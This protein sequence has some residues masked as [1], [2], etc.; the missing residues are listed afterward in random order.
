[1]KKALLVILLCIA[2]P[3]NADV[4]IRN[5]IS[6]ALADTLYVNVAGDTMTGGLLG[7]AGTAASVSF[8]FV[9][10]ADTGLFLSAANAIGFATAGT[11]RWLIN[12]SGSLNPATSNSLDI[13]GSTTIRDIG[14]GR[15]AVFSGATSGTTTVAA[16]AVAG[17]TTLTLPAATDTLVGKATTDTLSNKTFQ[18]PGTET[19]RAAGVIDVSSATVG[20]DAN[21]TEKTLYT[22]TLPAGTLD[23][24][25]KA[26]RVL[27]S[28]EF[29]ATATVKTL[30]FKFGAT[31]FTV[32]GQTTSPNGVIWVSEFVVI[33]TSATAQ[34][35]SKRTTVVGATNQN[36]SYST[37]AETMANAITI[38]VTGQNGTGNANDITINSALIILEQ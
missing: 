26:I 2:L 13:G 8:G 6:R 7:K 11:E 36:V 32:N 4:F 18:A 27:I 33:R 22:Y 31:T 17:T 1:M 38:L 21:T 15:N 12:A 20:T 9:G 25:G 34:F 19:Y 10:E 24:D 30:R 14:I 3:L 23:A 28:G 37:A 16:T 29:A 5:A 35:I